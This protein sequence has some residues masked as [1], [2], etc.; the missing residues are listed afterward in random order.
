VKPSS[1]TKSLHVFAMSLR[2]G[3]ACIYRVSLPE[4]AEDGKLPHS[5]V[6]EYQLQFKVEIEGEEG[7]EERDLSF[8]S[9]WQN[10]CYLS[11]AI[12]KT[13]VEGDTSA[14]LRTAVE[15]DTSFWLAIRTQNKAGPAVTLVRFPSLTKHYPKVVG[16]IF[17]GNKDVLDLAIDDDEKS[18]I[19]HASFDLWNLCLTNHG[20][21]VGVASPNGDFYRVIQNVIQHRHQNVDPAKPPSYSLS[22]SLSATVL[23][24]PFYAKFGYVK[25]VC[26]QAVAFFAISV[27]IH[28]AFFA[29]SVC[30]HSLVSYVCPDRYP[31]K[32]L[33]LLL[34]P[35]MQQQYLQLEHLTK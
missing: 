10:C 26:Q 14:N 19:C 1:W 33:L 25:Y 17:G 23:K 27:C 30:I 5:R 11:S 24:S 9:N 2:S 16:G 4:I 31:G 3:G 13:T 32:L 29:I 7:L 15:P 28:S 22:Y 35:L 34:L 20:L 21:G 8:L 6:L 12:L 18:R